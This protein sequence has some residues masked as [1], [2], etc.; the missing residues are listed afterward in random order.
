[1]RR[2]EIRRMRRVG[3]IDQV[4]IQHRGAGQGLDAVA[5]GRRRGADFLDRRID[6]D[7]AG[8]RV[9]REKVARLVERGERMDLTGGKT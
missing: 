2:I 9:T 8:R 3:G 4:Q 1:M 6:P 5:P 7:E